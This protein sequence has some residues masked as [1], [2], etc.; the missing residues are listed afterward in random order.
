M[1]GMYERSGKTIHS[2]IIATCDGHA[3]FVDLCLVVDHAQNFISS[4]FRANVEGWVGWGC[5]KG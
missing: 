4:A 3:C 5:H 1:T 2:I